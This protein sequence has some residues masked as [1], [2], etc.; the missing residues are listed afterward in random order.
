M[1]LAL[2]GTMFSS[3]NSPTTT[4]SS[5]CTA[6]DRVP[7]A[8]LVRKKIARLI[9]CPCRVLHEIDFCDNNKYPTVVDAKH[10]THS[11]RYLFIC[12]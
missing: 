3:D 2:H 10:P 6:T 11:T 1:T 8:T 7:V 12:V 9:P 4:D 5:S